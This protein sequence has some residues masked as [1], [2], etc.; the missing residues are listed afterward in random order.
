MNCT[1]SPEGALPGV[2][3]GPSWQPNTLFPDLLIPPFPY[4]KG[5]HVS[6]PFIL[7]DLTDDD[8]PTLTASH[9]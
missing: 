1:L 7:Y 4:Y 6:A 5:P 8:G 2:L 9:S 3:P